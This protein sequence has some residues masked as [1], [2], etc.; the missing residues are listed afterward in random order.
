MNIDKCVTLRFT[1]GTFPELDIGLY[2]NYSLNGTDIQK[3]N[4]HKD[5]GVL[6]D[7]SLRFQL[8]IK[9]IANKAAGL[10]ANLLKAI[11]C[12]SQKFMLTLVITHV[13]PLLEYCSCLWNTGYLG[14]LHMLETVERSWT[15]HR[16]NDW[17][18]LQ[19]TIESSRPLLCTRTPNSC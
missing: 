14:D 10:A 9:A 7:S 13:R 1:R 2:N 19:R 17:T 4:A 6:V 8:N 12:I 3:V 15:R 18:V 16:R 11:I 5:L